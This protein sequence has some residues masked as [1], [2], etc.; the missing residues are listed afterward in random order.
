MQTSHECVVPQC[1]T[2]SECR[3]DDTR[4]RCSLLTFGCYLPPPQCPVKSGEPNNTTASATVMTSGAYASSICRGDVDVLSFL[5]KP[6]K[7][8]KIK[9]KIDYQ[10]SGTELALLNGVG[11][12][13][14]SRS[15]T[16]SSD[17]LSVAGSN[18]TD[19]PVR[20]FVRINAAG[21]AKD[22]WDYNVEVIE[23]DAP[24]AA[25]CASTNLGEGEPNDSIEN[26]KL[27]EWG[28]AT[29]KTFAFNRC[30]QSDID[31]FK[32]L[33]PP[34]HGLDASVEYVGDQGKLD[35]LLCEGSECERPWDRDVIA[36]GTNGN[37]VEQVSSPEGPAQLWF[38][39]SLPPYQQSDDWERD[40]PYQL[41]IKLNPRPPE[42]ASDVGE[43]GNDVAPGALSLANNVET[44]G[45]RCLGDVDYYQIHLPPKTGSTIAL[46]FVQDEGDLRLDLLNELG[47]VIDSANESRSSAGIEKL[48]IL[49]K[50]NA[51]NYWARVRLN[52]SATSTAQNY[53]ISSGTYDGGK[54]FDKET[55]LR[56]PVVDHSASICGKD[57]PDWYGIGPITK[58]NRVS[59]S[60]LH[61][62]LQ[63]I[64][65]L[66]I[67][68]KGS[69][70]Q[71]LKKAQ[72]ANLG[73][74]AKVT[75]DYLVLEHASTQREYFIRVLAKEASDPKAQPYSLSVETKW[76]CRADDYE[77]E[78][79]NNDRARAT[80]LRA[81][82]VSERYNEEIGASICQGDQDHFKLLYALAGEQIDI[83]VEGPSGIALEVEKANGL[84][85]AQ[86]SSGQ[87]LRQKI[88]VDRG[89]EI[90]FKVFGESQAFEG[91]YR[92]RVKVTPA[93]EG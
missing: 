54:C 85:I 92:L 53:K 27:L 63:G 41:N 78:S 47:Q 43:P 6:A 7:R 20:Y 65:G 90:H 88:Q 64:L 52:G 84:Q 35:L 68:E 83:E 24:R 81:V 76:V 56:L 46:E 25:D 33:L 17:S 61:D 16:T 30:G 70:G 50:Q 36:K 71:L 73:R 80:N 23:A 28:N 13:I 26:A 9:L 37:N 67:W 3:Q 21:S 57:R 10:S 74:A 40:Q 72:N 29:S 2:D 22:N 19:S 11:E 42:C 87:L 75:V 60:L 55:L 34:Q 4:Y 48:H 12:V 59:A 5:A 32:V 93:P 31:Y 38:R 86:D 79:G 91:E 45:L 18:L 15:M 51:Q 62:P 1:V 66:E 58:G 39:V 14:Q 69:Q 77:K 89:Q 49:P 44:P 8:Y 82:G